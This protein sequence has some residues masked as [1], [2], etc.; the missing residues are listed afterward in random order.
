VP[1]FPLIKLGNFKISKLHNLILLIITILIAIS[2]ECVQLIIP[3]I[4][5]NV[6]DMLGNG[7]GALVGIIIWVIFRN[8]IVLKNT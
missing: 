2:L 4:T 1:L 5:F 8:K 7:I 6:N 3:W